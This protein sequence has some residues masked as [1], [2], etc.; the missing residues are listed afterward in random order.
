VSYQE[1]EMKCF[2][3]SCYEISGN[4]FIYFLYIDWL[5]IDWLIYLSLYWLIY[6]Y[7]MP[8]QNGKLLSVFEINKTYIIF[9]YYGRICLRV[10][11]LDMT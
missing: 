2:A 7:K 3:Y 5:I 10:T 6:L 9:F 4:A 11:S 8:K 1:K